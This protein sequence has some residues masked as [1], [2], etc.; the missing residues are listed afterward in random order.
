MEVT[1]LLH[2][3]K[4]G[5]HANLKILQKIQPP[6]GETGTTIRT[7][8]KLLFIVFLL[9]AKFCISRSAQLQKMS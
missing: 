3:Y 5:K 9:F 7:F 8:V 2:T 4:F 6:E 1:V